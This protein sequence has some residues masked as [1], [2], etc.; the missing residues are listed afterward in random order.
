MKLPPRLIRHLAHSQ[1]PLNRW[2]VRWENGLLK[3]PAIEFYYEPGD[4]HS[5][6]AAQLLPRVLEQTLTPVKIFIVSQQESPIYPELARQRQYNVLDAQRIAPAYDLSFPANAQVVS[7]HQRQIAAQQLLAVAAE[8]ERFVAEEARIARTLFSG[9]EMKEAL[10]EETSKQLARNNARREKLGHYLPGMWQFNGQWFWA[11]DRFDRLVAAVAAKRLW[12]G[13][14]PALPFSPEKA[15]LPNIPANTPV[16]CFLSFRSPYSFIA[17]TVLQRKR[18]SLNAA[19]DIRPVLPMA[20]RGFKVPLAKR[21]YILRDAA[22]EASSLNID[23]GLCADP[24][25][26][27]AIRALKAF[28]TAGSPE[29]KL[30][31]IVSAGQAAWSEARDL[32]TDQGLRH[33]CDDAGLTWREVHQALNT[34]NIDYAENN[35]NALFEAGLWGVPSFRMGEFAIWGQDRLWMIEEVVRRQN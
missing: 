8:P 1:S 35:R 10:R 18:E 32:A 27:G 11:V 20:M 23:F 9:D 21:L 6:L 24:I 30:D 7:E 29:Q 25:G 4:P 26:D 28:T 22:R 3:S 19:L 12:Q 31:F 33:A 17:A 14:G 2:R 16:E 13:N 34:A 5:H 15:A